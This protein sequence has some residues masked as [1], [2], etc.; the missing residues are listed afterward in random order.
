MVIIF[1]L[2][3]GIY[4][5]HIRIRSPVNSGSL[6]YNYK[7]YNSNILLAITDSKYHTL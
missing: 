1:D 6:F 4:G 2:L 3:K 7:G 5:K